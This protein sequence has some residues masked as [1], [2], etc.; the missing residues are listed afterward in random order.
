MTD[1][2][3]EKPQHATRP[4]L[5]EEQEVGSDDPETQAEIILAES[6]ARTQDPDAGVGESPSNV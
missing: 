3:D 1:T 4:M 6:E 2:A 5:P